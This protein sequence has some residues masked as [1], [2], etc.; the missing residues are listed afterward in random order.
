MS[1][2]CLLP[3][4]RKHKLSGWAGAD[5]RH[6]GPPTPLPFNDKRL[7]P[8]QCG[9][10]NP[11]CVLWTNCASA[12]TSHPFGYELEI[13]GTYPFLNRPTATGV[14]VIVKFVCEWMPPN[15]LRPHRK[16]KA[17]VAELTGFASCPP[18]SC[19]SL[20]RNGGLC[21]AFRFGHRSRYLPRPLLLGDF[22]DYLTA[23]S[24]AL[25]SV[26]RCVRMAITGNYITHHRAHPIFR[27]WDIGFI[28]HFILRAPQGISGCAVSPTVTS[29]TVIS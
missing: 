1:A 15:V 27:A 18:A 13:T 19:L 12:C 6:T 26:F 5:L 29:S 22:C 3:Q 17:G 9:F 4:L 2:L 20:D 25:P 8:D 16:R 7:S 24:P 10:Q 11:N 28:E 23:S 14:M 21:M